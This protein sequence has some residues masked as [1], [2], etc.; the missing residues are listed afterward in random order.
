MSRV[1]SFHALAILNQQEQWSRKSNNKK[2][3]T[4]VNV[5]LLPS[6]TYTE[7]GTFNVWLF[8]SKSTL[9]DKMQVPGL[10][11]GRRA[12]HLNR[13]EFL[14]AKYLAVRDSLNLWYD[15]FSLI[16]RDVSAGRHISWDKWLRM[17]FYAN[18]LAQSGPTVSHQRTV[19]PDLSRAHQPR[20]HPQQR[21]PFTR[22]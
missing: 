19:F 11:K 9:I 17:H 13:H 22:V 15:R 6:A 18:S 21:T 5:S 14:G 20:S 16:I 3:R 10:L 2:R 1:S 12:L 8:S 4:V 7:K